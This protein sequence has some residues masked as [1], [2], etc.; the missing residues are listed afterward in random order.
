MLCQPFR[1]LTL[2]LK[3]NR[4]AA[5]SWKGKVQRMGLPGTGGRLAPPREQGNQPLGVGSKARVRL[6][7]GSP[8]QLRWLAQSLVRVDV[9]FAAG[10]CVCHVLE[11]V[12]ET[13]DQAAAQVTPTSE[14]EQ[15]GLRRCPGS[16]V[17]S[18]HRPSPWVCHLPHEAA[19][20]AQHKVHQANLIGDL[21]GD[22][23][24]AVRAYCLHRRPLKDFSLQHCHCGGSP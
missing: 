2:G 1:L 5:N 22:G 21:G 19:E 16:Q 18:G 3:S 15:E 9:G 24:L 12:D 10:A 4:G 14:R 17:V 8:V 6:S 23:L 11:V 20:E 7:L 13:G